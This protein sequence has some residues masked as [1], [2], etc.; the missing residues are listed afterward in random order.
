[1]NSASRPIVGETLNKILGASRANKS[2]SRMQSNS[3]TKILP[4]PP[5]VYTQSESINRFMDASIGSMGAPE[6]E[7]P[8][9][10]SFVGLSQPI[11]NSF[12]HSHPV[13]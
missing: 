7:L 1:M 5:N 12:L 8:L 10:R 11:I 2:V 6:I 13:A 9:L 3:K 4:P